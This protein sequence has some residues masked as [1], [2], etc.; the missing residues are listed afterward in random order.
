MDQIGSGQTD[1]RMGEN[2]NVMM[3][4]SVENKIKL[5]FKKNK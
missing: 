3:N 2:D 5:N 4:G 1:R